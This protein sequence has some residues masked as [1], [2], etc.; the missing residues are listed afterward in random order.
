MGD[1]NIETSVSNKACESLRNL[2]ETLDLKLLDISGL[3]RITE[4]TNTCF[5]HVLVSSRFKFIDAFVEKSNLGDHWVFCWLQ[6]K[7][8]R[9]L[10]K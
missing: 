3:T 7:T 6:I 8:I 4:K 5:D 10:M 2:V 1:F 9:L